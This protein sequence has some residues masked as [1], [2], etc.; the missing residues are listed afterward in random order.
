MKLIEWEVSEGTE[1]SRLRKATPCQGGRR[2]GKDRSRR[3]EI[4]GREG[5]ED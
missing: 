2:S 3:S 1:V 5:A 4:G